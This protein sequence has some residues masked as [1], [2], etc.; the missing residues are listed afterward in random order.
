VTGSGEIRL[1]CFPEE[2][3]L[4]R[5]LFEEYA[6]ELGIDLCFQNFAQELDDLA[7]MYGLPRGQ[8]LLA[9][10]AGDP[11]G[12]VGVRAF[13][14]DTCEMKRLYVRTDG[15]G[16]AFGRRLALAAIDAARV[17]GYRRML[18][19]TLGSMTVART[20]YAALGFQ[21]IPA[22]YSNPTTDVKFMALDLRL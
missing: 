6:A 2:L 13:D 17:L 11:V 1:A 8:L 4:V 18:L 16:R 7:G 10:V 20:L 9:T 19:D 21:E 3:S 5:A 15:R 12:C 22:Y 14:G